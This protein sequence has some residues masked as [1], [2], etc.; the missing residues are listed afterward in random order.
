M[1]HLSLFIT[2]LFCSTVSLLAQNSTVKTE[3]FKVYGNCGMCKSTIEKAA[4]SVKGVKSAAWD[5]K[6]DTITVS[7]DTKLTTSDAILQ[8]IAA[9]GYDSDKCRATD[10]AYYKLHGCCQYERP[11]K[12][13]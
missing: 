3:Q 5:M 2:M 12:K 4:N 6:T 10:E 11:K 13:S 7:Y 9:K 8:A 1:K